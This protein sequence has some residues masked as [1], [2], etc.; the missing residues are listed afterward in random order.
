M[1]EREF[2]QG[3]FSAVDDACA[4]AH[5]C[6]SRRV[7]AVAACTMHAADRPGRRAVSATA[8]RPR[9]YKRSS[10]ASACIW[11]SNRSTPRPPAAVRGC[12]RCWLL[13]DACLEIL[14]VLDS[15]KIYD[16][17]RSNR[18][19]VGMYGRKRPFRLH[20]A[21]E[22]PE[23][24]QATLTNLMPHVK[25]PLNSQF[26]RHLE[27]DVAWAPR[28]GS[29]AL[30][31]GGKRAWPLFGP[32]EGDELVM[33]WPMWEKGY[34]DVIANTLIP[35]GNMM[36]H[37]NFPRHLALSGMRHASLLPPLRG[38]A[39]SVCATE[40]PNPPLLPR[41]A[42]ACWRTVR[43][44]APEFGADARDSWHATVAL[45]AAAGILPAAERGDADGERRGSVR[46]L[47]V[48]IA[49]RHGRR[50]LAE[51]DA[52]GRQ[53]DG[54]E[55]GGRRL[56]CRVLA[57]NATPAAKVAA[58]R[59]ANVYVCVWGAHAPGT[60][61]ASAS[62]RPQRL[63]S[64]PA[65]SQ[66]A[67]RCTR[68]TCARARRCSSSGLRAS[69]AARR[70]RGSTCTAGGSRGSGGRRGSSRSGSFRCSCRS[71]RR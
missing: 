49:A 70:T 67:T 48:L 54:A 17:P 36:R 43:I 19:G 8:P 40:R 68:C 52:L 30:R 66:V 4:R 71:T 21:G 59:W 60:A 22:T 16:N 23:A 57:A 6:P 47:R 35:F 56:A 53:C 38:A 7:G 20:V 26:I 2:R 33:V 10:K 62:P 28:N 3:N 63:T 39:S 51:P 24:L 5:G 31:G 32:A 64:A 55:L 25:D 29:V 12:M 13:S 61:R 1:S 45:D 50:L 27:N 37:G 42:S 69:R 34:G 41:C 11:P 14:P 65:A 15:T 46:A 9:R 58:L 44:C 18:Y